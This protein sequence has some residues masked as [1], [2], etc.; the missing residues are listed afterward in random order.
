VSTLR[1]EWLDV[2][3]TRPDLPLLPSPA[4]VGAA[5]VAELRWPWALFAH[6]AFGSAERPLLLAC[7]ESDPDTAAALDD[8]VAEHGHRNLVMHAIQPETVAT[9]RALGFS[10]DRRWLGRRTAVTGDALGPVSEQTTTLAARPDLADAYVTLLNRSRLFLPIEPDVF[11]RLLATDPMWQPHELLVATHDDA[12]VAILRINCVMATGRRFATARNLVSGTAPLPQ[13]IRAVGE[14]VEL[15]RAIQ[16]QTG[17][18]HNWVT[19]NPRDRGLARLHRKLSYED[20]P[21]TLHHLCRHVTSPCPLCRKTV[22]GSP[23]P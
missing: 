20:T 9:A 5:A 11:H 23:G 16:Y 2:Y 8:V 15:S 21:F 13:R 18:E 12:A 19:V 14:L 22:Q 10:V 4:W 3:E 7:S 6:D 17:V 1:Q